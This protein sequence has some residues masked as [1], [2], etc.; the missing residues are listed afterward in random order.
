M[1]AA[2][3]SN[4][5]RLIRELEPEFDF[6][7]SDRED[8]RHI[9]RDKFH[10][11]GHDEEAI[12]DFLEKNDISEAVCIGYRRLFSGNF[13]EKCSIDIYNLHPSLLP[14]FKGLNVYERVLESDEGK[15]G[16]TLHKIVEEMDE[17]EIIA[18]RS[19][20]I[21]DIETVDELKKKAR[22]VELSLIRESFL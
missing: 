20:N 15:S 7:I 3:V 13:L 8:L 17:G 21:E 22:E 14:D 9:S 16:A 12:L 6:I 5:E 4:D 11:L 1:K 2:F 19:Y 18:Q 10:N